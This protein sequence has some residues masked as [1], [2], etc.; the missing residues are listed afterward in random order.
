MSRASNG[1]GGGKITYSFT[2][3]CYTISCM[4][5]LRQYG[6]AKQAQ[7]LKICGGRGGFAGASRIFIAH[8]TTGVYIIRNLFIFRV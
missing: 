4:R 2:H 7:Y 3:D 6:L 8:N 5:T 1:G